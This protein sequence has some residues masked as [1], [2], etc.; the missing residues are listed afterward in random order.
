MPTRLPRR[1]SAPG[2]DAA[3]SDGRC[4]EH[5]TRV[6][7]SRDLGHQWYDLQRW[8]HPVYG[9]RA[10]CLRKDPLCV[11]CQRL[12][13]VTAASEVDHVIP[14]RGDPRLFWDVENLRGLCKQHHAAKTARG[15]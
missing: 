9:R 3:T 4:A 5:H 1:C 12:G 10:Q 8:R 11:E 15:E 14:H 13:R 7:H 6:R 2:C